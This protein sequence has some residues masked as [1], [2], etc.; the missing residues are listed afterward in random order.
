ME[1][2]MESKL[3][4]PASA[5]HGLEAVRA[6]HPDLPALAAIAE[7]ITDAK[8]D[9]NELTLTVARESVIPAT[10]ALKAAGYNF[11]EDVTCVDWYPSEPRFHHHVSHPVA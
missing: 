9:R 5:L 7:L 2:R 4:N 10:T 8:Y 1:E 3:Y 6:A 11:L